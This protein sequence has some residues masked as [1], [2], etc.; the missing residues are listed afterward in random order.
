MPSCAHL[1]PNA[2]EIVCLQQGE[3]HR[4]TAHCCFESEVFPINIQGHREIGQAVAG[5]HF[6]S[7]AVAKNQQPLFATAQRRRDDVP[8]T[9]RALLAVSSIWGEVLPHDARWTAR[10]EHWLQVIRRQGVA[11]ALAQLSASD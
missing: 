4:V 5:E 8:G 9:V 10:V 7:R 2:P 3:L 11:G 6:Q 1:F